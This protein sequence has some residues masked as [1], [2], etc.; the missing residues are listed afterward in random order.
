MRECP[1]CEIKQKHHIVKVYEYWNVHVADSQQLLG[2]TIISLKEH[3][4]QLASLTDEEILEF[5]DIC[6]EI[7][8]ALDKAF[9]PDWYNYQQFGNLNRHLHF[10]LIPRYMH[11]RLFEGRQFVDERFGKSPERRWIFEEEEFL[12]KLAEKIRE[13][14]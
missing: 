13:K 10:Y 7:Q 12:E 3:K 5:R 9:Q 14:I 11:P 2:Y 6:K 4:E 8:G 1:F